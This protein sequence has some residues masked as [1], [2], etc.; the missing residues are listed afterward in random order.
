MGQTH[1][2]GNRLYVS[3]KL[4]PLGIL[5]KIYDIIAKSAYEGQ[6]TFLVPLGIVGL[7]PFAS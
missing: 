4:G 6:E 1:P 3:A 7:V 2:E 5:S